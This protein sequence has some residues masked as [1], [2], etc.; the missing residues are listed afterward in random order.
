[1]SDERSTKETEPSTPDLDRRPFLID[2]VKPSH[3]PSYE[4]IAC[5]GCDMNSSMSEIRLAAQ[6]GQVKRDAAGKS[7]WTNQVR[8][9]FRLLTSSP[10]RLLLDL[11]H[12]QTDPFIF[13]VEANSTPVPESS[14]CEVPKE[15]KP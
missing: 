7:L 6:R 13:R 3:L 15:N 10:R 14:N 12:V 4:S 5:F 1:M 9:Q 2:G 11:F 8:E